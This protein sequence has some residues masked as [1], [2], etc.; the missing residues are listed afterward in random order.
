MIEQMETEVRAALAARA[1]EV[2]AAV[3]GR[4]AG[5][6]YRPRTRDLRRPVAAGALV[7][8]AWPR[9]SC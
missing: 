1:D 3:A 7:A 2:P 4:V 6:G 5:R 9:A 8:P